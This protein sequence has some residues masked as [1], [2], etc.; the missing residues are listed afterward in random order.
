M[1]NLFVEGAM[2][3]G[4]SVPENLINGVH[5][6]LQG[7]VRFP[8]RPD[9]TLPV[10]VSEVGSTAN[11]ANAFPVKAS[12]REVDENVKP[13]MTAELTLL[14]A[15]DT[16]ETAYLIPLRAI[17]AGSQ[18][19]GWF[20][21]LFD[22]ASS[23]VKKTPVEGRGMVGDQVMI[24]GGVEPGDVVVVAGVSFLRD[25]QKVKLLKPDSQEL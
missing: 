2:E 8:N 24:T 7:E 13:G 17:A 10:I 18:N 5:L 6:G 12:I 25:A 20:V 4:V 11:N 14:F 21:Y 16:G 22:P 9:R 15:N 19:E 23:T 1:L 3:V